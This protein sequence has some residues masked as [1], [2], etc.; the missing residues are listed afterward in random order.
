MQNTSYALL[1][2]V[3][4][5]WN[6]RGAICIN[7]SSLRCI[8]VPYFLKFDGSHWISGFSGVNRLILM[9]QTHKLLQLPP[10]E[11]SQEGEEHIDNVALVSSVVLIGGRSPLLLLRI[12]CCKEQQSIKIVMTVARLKASFASGQY[13]ISTSWLPTLGPA[14]G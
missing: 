8:L 12:Q 3:L 7:F 4:V 14:S 1:H 11:W 2:F 6:V 13:S 9:D 10:M 5:T